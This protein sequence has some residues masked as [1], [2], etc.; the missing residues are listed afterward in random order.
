MTTAL[1]IDP[2]DH[3]LRLHN[4]PMSYKPDSYFSDKKSCSKILVSL[5]NP[6]RQNEPQRQPRKET[7]EVHR[8]PARTY[9]VMLLMHAT[10]RNRNG[11]ELAEYGTS[12]RR[13]SMFWS[14][15]ETSIFINWEKAITGDYGMYLPI[16]KTCVKSMRSHILNFNNTQGAEAIAISM[17][18][19][20]IYFKV[21]QIHSQ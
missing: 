19:E 9:N 4:I 21:Q 3:G 11:P 10:M 14:S 18:A 20:Q 12:A 7:H 6:T 1:N 8:I 13:Y 17:L 2:H 5:P 15:I 16:C